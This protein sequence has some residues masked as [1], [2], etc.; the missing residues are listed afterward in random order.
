[1]TYLTTYIY[2][3]ILHMICIDKRKKYGYFAVS[4]VGMNGFHV[5]IT[6]SHVSAPI[7]NV[8]ALIGKNPVRVSKRGWS[9]DS[10]IKAMDGSLLIDLN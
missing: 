8:T 10:S 9:R 5:T 2:H 1:M 6:K 3:D 4:D 7:Q